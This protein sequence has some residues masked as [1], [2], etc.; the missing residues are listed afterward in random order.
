VTTGISVSLAERA[1]IEAYADFA[2]GTP[3]AARDLLGM[4]E[5]RVGGG[6]VMTVRNDSTRFWT[7]AGGFGFAEPVTVDLVA[8]VCDFF[9]AQDM[10]RGTLL[11]APSVLPGDWADIRAKLDIA[12]GGRYVKLVCDVDSVLDRSSLLDP[13][14][15]VGPV[16]VAQAREWSSVMMR[17]F[18]FTDDGMVDMGASAIGRP[19]WHPFA[20]WDGDEIIAT[21]ATHIHED[22]AHMF[23]AATVQRARGRGAQSALLH[24]RAQVARAAGCRWLIAET[25]AEGPQQHST[26]LHNMLRAGFQPFYER[27][28]WAWRPDSA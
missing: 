12:E 7:K 21:A 6:R 27:V 20:V 25:G 24:A 23:G 10:P 9:R 11:L 22:S 18:G 14:L 19:D 13:A 16:D 8:Q 1:E 15:R 17:T 4:A 26:S 28:N 5:F 3:A 2:A